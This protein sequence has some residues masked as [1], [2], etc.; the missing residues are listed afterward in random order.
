MATVQQFMA[1]KATEDVGNSIL[2]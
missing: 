1:L 2:E